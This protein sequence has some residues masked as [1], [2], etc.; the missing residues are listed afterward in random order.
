MDLETTPAESI[1][2]HLRAHQTTVEDWPLAA[3]VKDFHDWAERMIVEFKLEIGVKARE[4]GAKRQT[5][6][7]QSRKRE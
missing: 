2:T 4:P 6:D 7:Q 3:V 5:S 1:N